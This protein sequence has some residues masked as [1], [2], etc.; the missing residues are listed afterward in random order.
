MLVYKKLLK[1]REVSKSSK[2]FIKSTDINDKKR[3]PVTELQKNIKVKTSNVKM[4][5]GSKEQKNLLWL[6]LTQ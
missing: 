1:E 5:E 2:L 3:K 6:P 4:T